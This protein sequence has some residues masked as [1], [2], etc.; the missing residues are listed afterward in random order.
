MRLNV[1]VKPGHFETP[2]SYLTRFCAANGVD[3]AYY[4]NAV[5]SRRQATGD[6]TVLGA[7]IEELGGPAADHWQRSHAAASVGFANAC[8]IRDPFGRQR[9]WRIACTHCSGGADVTTYDHIRSATCLKHRRWCGP[10]TTNETQRSLTDLKRVLIAERTARRLIP[11]GWIDLDLYNTCWEAV[12]DW[13][14][15]TGLWSPALQSAAD[16]HGFVREVDDRAALYPETVRLLSMV[17][18][19]EFRHLCEAASGGSTRRRAWMH[20][21]LR[22]L[23]IERWIVAEAIEECVEDRQ[24]RLRY[25]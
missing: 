2:Q 25:R 19:P 11:Q 8:G 23:P 17:S 3:V 1:P 4:R 18:N 13:T 22:W 24:S 7:V 16:S 20:R 5:R 14:Y 9:A 12:R 15:M 10:G 6:S 21:E